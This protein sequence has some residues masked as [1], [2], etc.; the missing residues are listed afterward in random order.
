[1]FKSLNWRVVRST[2]GRASNC[3]VYEARWDQIIDFVAAELIVGKLL[4][5]DWYISLCISLNIIICCILHHS[6]ATWLP[7][8]L[9]QDCVI[10]YSHLCEFIYGM[11]YMYAMIQAEVRI[12]V[13]TKQILTRYV[14]WAPC[15]SSR[16]R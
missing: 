3:C 8:R 5:L 1:M 6:A 10:K 9:Q 13:G 12:T 16:G 14:L 7:V 4:W 15:K 11:K 2:D